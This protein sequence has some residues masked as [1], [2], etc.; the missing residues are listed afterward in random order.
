MPVVNSKTKLVKLSN[1][2]RQKFT[3]S[4]SSFNRFN[5]EEKSTEAIK[6]E[7]KSQSPLKAVVGPNTN[8]QTNTTQAK[9]NAANSAKFDSPSLHSQCF[10][11]EFTRVQSPHVL[12]KASNEC[13]FISHTSSLS[14]NAKKKLNQ[15]FDMYQSSLYD[16]NSNQNSN[17]SNLSNVST[18]GVSLPNLSRYEVVPPTTSTTTNAASTTTNI[19]DNR[20]PTKTFNLQKLSIFENCLS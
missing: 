3:S 4:Y 20:K 17:G 8:T 11:I 19:A 10:D 5:F 9:V 6:A 15:Q 18:H 13:K 2:L 14:V 7:N 16:S 12:G 1:T